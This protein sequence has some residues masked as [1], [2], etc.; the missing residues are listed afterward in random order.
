MERIEKAYH[1]S[2]SIVFRYFKMANSAANLL[3]TPFKLPELATVLAQM[4]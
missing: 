2:H 1:Y 3:L 4:R